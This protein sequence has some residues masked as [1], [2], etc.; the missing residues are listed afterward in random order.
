MSVDPAPKAIYEQVIAA[1]SNGDTAT[2]DVLFA[3]NVV[4]HNPL[5]E[6]TAGLEGFKQW[7]LAARSSFPDLTG[8]VE[9]VV[10]EGDLV[11][12]RVTWRGTQRGWLLGLAPTNRVIAFA[13]FHFVKLASGLIVEWHGTAD[14]LGAVEQAGGQVGPR[15]AEPPS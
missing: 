13:A 5:P 9:A 15:R 2:L 11:A 6:Q 12:G 3:Q 1:V 7:M 8:T 4:D 10:S 14:L